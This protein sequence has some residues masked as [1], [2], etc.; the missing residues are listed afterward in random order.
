LGAF[1]LC[2]LQNLGIKMSAA[3]TKVELSLDEIIKNNKKEQKGGNRNVRRGAGNARAGVRRK[4]QGVLKRRPVG[5]QKNRAVLKR[6]NVNK[7][8]NQASASTINK[9]ATQRLV[10]KL[11][12]KALKQ[13]TVARAPKIGA[14]RN[15]IRGRRGGIRNR[16]QQRNNA[17]NRVSQRSRVI[18]RRSRILDRAPVISLSNRPRGGRGN[19]RGGNRNA[20]VVLARS[21]PNPIRAQL[22]FLRRQQQRS[23]RQQVVQAPVIR[24][25]QQQRR[26]FPVQRRQATRVIYVQE[27]RPPPVRRQ[28]QQ[29][30]YVQQ[31]PRRQFSRGGRRPQG[32][33]NAN[34]P[35]YEPPNFLQRVP[36][37]NQSYSRGRGGRF[38]EF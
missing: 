25:Q 23:Q 8:G 10:S 27:Q 2:T 38:I 26:S 17:L 29:I 7:N 5:A 32:R 18:G 22:N 13:V 15:V 21:E 19:R 31:Q 4:G 24:Q 37:S 11:V 33:N 16:G 36:S 12:K 6:S 35:F 14:V 28:Q 20:Q 34:N 9:V 3:K 1:Q 30:V